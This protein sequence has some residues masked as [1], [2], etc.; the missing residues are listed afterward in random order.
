[1]TRKRSRLG[2]RIDHLAGSKAGA[3]FFIHIGNR[4]DKVLM[5]LTRGRLST[6]MAKPTLLLHT[7][8]AKSGEPRT[9]P[10]VFLPDGERVIVVAS[11][12]GN[13]RS[14]AWSHNLR[15]HPACE[16]TIRGRRRAFV[17]RVAVGEERAGLWSRA[18]V[19]YE[20]FDDYD[21]RARASREIPVFVL[22]PS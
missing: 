11:N 12:G 16:A 9:A 19:M 2:K 8:G 18:R 1:M 6:S 14:P 7:V 15:A 17:A 13:E 5:P 3:W 21:E 22:D 4:V 20:G 10:L